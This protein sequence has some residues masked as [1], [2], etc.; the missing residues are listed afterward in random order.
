MWIKP[1]R[2]GKFAVMPD[3]AVFESRALASDYI[4]TKPKSKNHG[5][6]N[7]KSDSKK[8]LC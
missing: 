6:K 3:V 5:V 8:A 7:R 1:L 4:V 2:N